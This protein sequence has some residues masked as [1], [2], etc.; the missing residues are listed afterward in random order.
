MKLLS[1]LTRVSRLSF[2]SPSLIVSEKTPRRC[3]LGVLLSRERHEPHSGRGLGKQVQRI[4]WAV[5]MP[6][7]PSCLPFPGTARPHSFSP[8][9]PAFRMQLSSGLLPWTL[10]LSPR[11][12]STMTCGLTRLL[13]GSGCFPASALAPVA[14]LAGSALCTPVWRRW[15]HPVRLPCLRSGFFVCLA[16]PLQ[17]RCLLS[18]PPP[19]FVLPP[20][21]SRQCL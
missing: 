12:S 2:A 8:P 15:A 13:A 20:R 6:P 21:R 10:A 9:A 17:W 4:C 7:P 11:A 5:I 14:P 18:P 16:S 1:L 3:W 19:Q